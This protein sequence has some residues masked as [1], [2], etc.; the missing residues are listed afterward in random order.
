MGFWSHMPHGCGNSTRVPFAKRSARKLYQL[1][2]PGAEGLAP[3][4]RRTTR[5]RL[6]NSTSIRGEGRL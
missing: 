2:I 5:V 4:W 6:A 1:R 3:A